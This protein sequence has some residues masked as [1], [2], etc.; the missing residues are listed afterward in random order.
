MMKPFQG[1]HQIIK[2]DL[3]YMFEK[4]MAV[5]NIP[6]VSY[7]RYNFFIITLFLW[8]ESIPVPLK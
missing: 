3:F 6:Q 7:T 5:L 4:L 1:K 2:T 8:H